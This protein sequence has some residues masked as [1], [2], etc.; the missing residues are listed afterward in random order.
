MNQA[1]LT[2]ILFLSSEKV[3]KRGLKSY[4]AVDSE[5]L[6]E[7]ISEARTQLQAL[8][9]TIIED[10]K[11]LELVCDKKYSKHAEAFFKSTPQELSQA[12]LEVL[13]IIAYN[14]PIS[15]LQ[16]D[17]MRGVSSEQSIRNLLN[18]DLIA[19]DGSKALPKYS[20][21]LDFLK[22]AGLKNIN[23]LPEDAKN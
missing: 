9:L 22:L 3:A 21:T 23:Q 15:K 20:T 4:L 14:Q 11:Y 16:I 18:K 10:D 12:S 13:S 5:K 1:S 6:S 2:T 17:E 7:L 8:G 19:A